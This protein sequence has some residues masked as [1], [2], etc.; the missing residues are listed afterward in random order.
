MAMAS[1]VYG[2]TLR[3]ALG[4]AGLALN[5]QSDVIKNVLVTNSHTPNFNTHTVSSDITNEVTGTGYTAGGAVAAS[6]TLTVSG[7]FLTHDAND[8]VWS[9]A[10]IANIRGRILVDDTLTGDPLIMATNFGQDFSVVAGTFTIQESAQ[11]IWR[12]ALT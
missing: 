9:N 4:S 12:I 3:N 8:T 10:T 2:T 11:G 7:G 5:L 6:S 1:G